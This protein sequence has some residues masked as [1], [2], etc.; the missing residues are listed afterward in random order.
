MDYIYNC[1]VVLVVIKEI[2][3]SKKNISL[4]F[5]SESE[6]LLEKITRVNTTKNDY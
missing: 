1:D 3:S 2:V 6:N 5:S 4:F